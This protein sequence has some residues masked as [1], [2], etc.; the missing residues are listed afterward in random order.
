MDFFFTS[1]TEM[2]DGEEKRG[3]L[4]M[5]TVQ[6]PGVHWRGALFI[7][8]SSCMALVSSTIEYSAWWGHVRQSVVMIANSY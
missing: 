3:E 1:G 6:L 5:R 8:F 7:H 4:R 2:E